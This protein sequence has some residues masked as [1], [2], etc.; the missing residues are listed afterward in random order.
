MVKPTLIRGGLTADDRGHVSFVNDFDFTGVRRF[1]QVSNH[2]EAMVRAWHAHREEEK[3]VLATR[4]AVLLCC[5][6]IDDWEAPSP[7]L[8][9]H[10]FVLSASTPAVVHIPAGYANGF[11]TLTPDAAA[12]FFSSSRLEDSVEDD[13]R[14]PA[15][16]WDPW[17]VEER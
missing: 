9:I 6:E 16:L 1:Y 4:G 15:R 8:E 13:I 3:W 11:M 12:L 17:F 14:F 10:R 7:D 5:V 2:R